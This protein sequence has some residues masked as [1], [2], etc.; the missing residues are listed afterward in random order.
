MRARSRSVAA[1]A[2]AVRE[3]ISSWVAATSQ[4]SANCSSERKT[5]ETTRYWTVSPLAATSPG[6]SASAATGPSAHAAAATSAQR[7]GRTISAE[8]ASVASM[9]DHAGPITASAATCT[10]AIAASVA[11]ACGGRSPRRP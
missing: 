9:N 3:R 5:T 11:S 7:T 8:T 10:A 1:S 4:T 2:S 6:C